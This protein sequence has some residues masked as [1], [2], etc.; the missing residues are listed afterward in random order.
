MVGRS[1]LCKA[2]LQLFP[3]QPC[4]DLSISQN[5]CRAKLTSLLSLLGVHKS[6]S[7]LEEGLCMENEQADRR[8]E[9]RAS[10]G[11]FHTD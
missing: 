7:A 4:K 11:T 6:S 3:A 1:H 9:V 2:H 10:R 5:N 8:E